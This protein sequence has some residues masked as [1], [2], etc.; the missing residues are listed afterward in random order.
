M[1]DTNGCLKYLLFS[2]YVSSTVC[3]S[4][5]RVR[6]HVLRTESD[7][8]V[9]RRRIKPL[10]IS[11]E[12]LATCSVLSINNSISMDIPSY[13]VRTLLHQTR[14]SAPEHRQVA[15]QPIRSGRQHF[16]TV[17]I[18]SKLMIRHY[19]WDVGTY[20]PGPLVFFHILVDVY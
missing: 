17:E 8:V 15:L 3:Y 20:K 2:Q 1:V 5:A 7:Q 14:C 16:H 10:Y 9:D 18:D 12:K 19:R 13:L 6:T 11:A 4:T